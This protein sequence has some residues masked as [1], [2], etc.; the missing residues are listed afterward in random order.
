L[1]IGLLASDHE[2]QFSKKEKKRPQAPSCHEKKKKKKKTPVMW[3]EKKWRNVR[4]RII[5]K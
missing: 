3:S 1:D 4:K 2:E 5:N